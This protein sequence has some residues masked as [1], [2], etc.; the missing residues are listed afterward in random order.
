MMDGPSGQTLGSG[1]DTLSFLLVLHNH[2]PLGNFDEVIQA[3]TDRAYRPFLEAIHARPALKFTLHLSGPLLLWLERRAPDYLDLI[4]DLVQRGRLELLSGGLYEP[5]LAAIPHEDRITQIT[6]MN[7]R[8]R[9]R[10]GVRPRGLWLTERIW[11]SAII[12]SLVDAGIAY[13]LMDDRAFLT[14]GFEAERLHDYYLTEGEDKLLAVFPIDKTLRYLIPF[15]PPTEIEAHLRRIARMGGRLA[16]AADDGEKFGGW[17]GTAQWVYKDGWLKG[18]LDLLEGAGDWLATQTVSEAL[19]HVA[20]AGLCYLPTC[21]YVEMEEWSLGPDG[22]RRFEELKSRLGP[23]ADRFMPHLRGGH[24]KHFLIR[25][26]EANRAHKKGLALGRLLPTGRGANR[27]RLEL[28]AAQC[29]DSYWHGIFGGLY[30]PHLR[31]EIWRHLARAEALIRRRQKVKVELSD[32]DSDGAPEVWISSSRGSAQIQPHRGGRLV[33]WTDFAGEINLLNTLTRRPELYHDAIRR[34]AAHPEQQTHEGIPG[35]HD[36]QRAAPA[37]LV[38]ALCY[39]QWERAA[40]L[41]HFFTEV[42]PLSAWLSGRLDERGDFIEALWG[43]TPTSGGVALDRVGRVRTESD[44][45]HPVLLR[46]EYAFMD[47]RRLTVLYRM[48]NQ[49][50]DR[51]DIRFGVELNFFLPGLAYG[52]SVIM[53]GDQRVS[54]DNPTY[55]AAVERFTVST[56]G[57]TP[58]LRIELNHPAILYSHLVAT[59]SQSEDGYERTVQ[60]VAAMPTWDLRLD[61]GEM[62]EGQVEVA[63]T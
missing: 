53:L 38:N 36:L 60:G 48:Q 43:F 51:L 6:L 5:V 33:E 23:D 24:W 11:D 14:S 44:L 1:R 20:P 57:P 2:Q 49:G 47:N 25:Y 37:D 30:L 34:A 15:R 52:Q 59:V 22:G 3:L 50:H 31:H 29:N 21:S 28:L 58:Q 18:F 55:A 4:G 26:P 42:D 16:I 35:I 40:F 12:P 61:P 63:L 39:D 9:S 10:F 45:S 8:L 46:K 27:A 56:N 17:P 13:V 41:D 54:L 32:V 62:W 7:E 19:D